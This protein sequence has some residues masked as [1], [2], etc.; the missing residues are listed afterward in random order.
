MVLFVGVL[1]EQSEHGGVVAVNAAVLA[2]RHN[3]RIPLGLLRVQEFG[4]FQWKEQSHG[5]S[6]RHTQY[7]PS[8]GHR[9]SWSWLQAGTGASRVMSG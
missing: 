5:K 8:G 7:T 2:M 4:S 9:W 3:G 1:G 6:F